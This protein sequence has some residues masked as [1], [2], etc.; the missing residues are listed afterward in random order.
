MAPSTVG[1]VALLSIR[2]PFASAIARGAKTVEYRR[3]PLAPDVTH[4]VIYAT[5]PVGRVLGLCEVTGQLVDTPERVWRATSE[6]GFIDRSYFNEYFGGRER[7]VAISLRFV[8]DLEDQQVDLA[9]LGAVRPPQSYQYLHSEV[10][11]ALAGE[12][13]ELA[14]AT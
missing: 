11:R 9:W 4:A 1:R 2:P 12:V 3:R 6:R 8:D 7:A 14:L 10:A 5:L 13:K